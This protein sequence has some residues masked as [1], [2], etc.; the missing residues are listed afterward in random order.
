VAIVERT[1]AERIT[2]CYG[3]Q[4][5]NSNIIINSTAALLEDVVYRAPITKVP[6]TS[7]KLGIKYSILVTQTALTKDAYNFWDNLS[8]NTEKLG[9]IFDAQPSQISGNI[10]NIADASEPVIG[11]ISAGTKQSKR[12]FISKLDLPA[13]Y[14]FDYPYPCSIDTAYYT[15]PVNQLLVPLTSINTPVE[16]IYPDPPTTW[17]IIGF[18]Y[19]KSK[20]CVDCTIRGRVAKPSFWQ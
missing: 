2:Y 6:S 5:S 18:T 16:A 14:K 19:T 3:Y 12:I 11:Y 20:P 7:E 9:S 15:T 1:A 10:H 17:T 4:P 8:K 13:N